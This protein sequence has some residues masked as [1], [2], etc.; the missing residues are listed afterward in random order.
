MITSNSGLVLERQEFT[1]K[2]TIGSIY[3]NGDFIC[4]SLELPWRDNERGKSCI[5]VGEYELEYHQYKNYLDTYALV[6]E[7]VSHWCGEDRLQRCAILLHPANEPHEIDG[8]IAPGLEKGV[9]MVDLSA[10]A[11]RKL[12]NTIICK[13]IDKITII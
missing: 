1:D 6:G 12:H 9:D 3:Y 8:C 13:N 4:Y 11:F 10:K 5:P 7:T 2:S